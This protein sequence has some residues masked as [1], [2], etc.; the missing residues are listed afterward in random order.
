M[1]F[2]RRQYSA[3]ADEAIDDAFAQVGEPADPADDGEDSS[4]A[5]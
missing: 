4:R 3:I 1:V 2:V 5:G